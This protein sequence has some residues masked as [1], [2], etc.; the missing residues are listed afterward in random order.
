MKEKIIVIIGPTAIGK[1]SFSIDVAKK[2]NGEVISG[3]SMQVYKK[4]N[5]GTA[6]VTTSEMENIPHHLID[7]KDIDESYTVANFQRDATDKIDEITKRNHVPIIVGGTGLYIESLLYP[8]TH[9]GDAEPNLELRQKLESFAHDNGPQELWNR[10]N[11]IDPSAAENIHPNNIRRVVRALEVY[12]ETGELFSSFQ[13]EK[14]NKEPLYDALIICLNTD[15]ELLYTRINQRVDE[16]IDD[17]LI[18]EAEWL[19]K[20]LG[21]NS[22]AQSTKG[23][24]YKELFTYFNN[25]KKLE[26]V[27]ELIKQNSRRYA[28]RQLTWFRNRLKNVYWYDFIKEPEEK[29]KSLEEIEEFLKEDSFG[30]PS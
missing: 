3:D 14:K 26:D 8:M 9:S 12:Y 11:N 5:I 18:N 6:K 25:E 21:P 29:N 27:I 28:K 23:I 10:L 7:M 2:F 24:G 20:E 16:M 17:G 22:E 13:K 1:T 19:W 15:R 30:K 4:L